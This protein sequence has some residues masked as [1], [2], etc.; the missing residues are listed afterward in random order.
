MAGP[1]IATKLHVPKPRRELVGRPRLR[2]LLPKEGG[3][4]LTLISAPAGFGKTTLLAEWLADASDGGAAVAW[5]SIDPADN[6]PAAFW[7]E[8]VAALQAAAAGRGTAFPAMPGAAQPDRSF[9]AI[10]VNEIAA[11]P[12]PVDLVLDDFHLIDHAEILDGLAF[13]IDHLPQHMRMVISTRADPALPLARLRARGELAEIRAAD[14][15]FTPSETAAYLNEV[16]GLGLTSGDTGTLE[17]RTEGWIAALQLAVLSLKGRDDV[18]GFIAEFAGSGRYIVDYLVEEVLQRQPEEVRRFLLQ[19]CILGRMSGSLC[20]A[21]TGR[22]GT[23]RPMLELLDRQNLFVV[24]L[25]DRRQWY[26]YHHLFADVLLSHMGEEERRE[27]PVLHRRASDWFELNGQPPEAIRHALAAEDFEWAA[28]LVE[29]AIPDMRRN[30]HEAIFRGWARLIPDHLIRSRP[31]LGAGYAGV[32]V[33]LGEFDGIEERLANVERELPGLAEPGGIPASI[34]LYRA[35]LAQVRGDIAAAARHAEL[36]LELAPADDHLVRAGAAGFLGIVHWTEG[37]LE[38]AGRSWT[39]CANGLRRA[40]HIADIFGATIAL[41]DIRTTEGRLTE[42]MRACESALDLATAGGR[43]TLRG[44]ADAHASLSLLHLERNEFAAARLQLGRSLGLGELFGLPQHPYRSLVARAR[45]EA[46]EGNLAAAL[47]HLGEAERRYVSD[48]FPNLRPIPAMKARLHIRLGRLDEAMRWQ[49]EAGVTADD[50][51]AFAREFEHLTL[52]RLLLA[53]AADDRALAGQALGLLDRLEPAALA[54]GRGG[55]VVE[56][57]VLRALA[58]RSHGDVSAALGA[59]R[60]ALER[61]EPE[62]HVRT[63]IDEG[64]PIT[65][66]LKLAARRDIVPA[67]ARRL[68]AAAGSEAASAPAHHPDLIEALS[69]REAELLR[70]LR[71]D[72]S[73]PDMARELGVSLNTVRTHT[74]NIYEKL[75][76]NSRRAAVRRAEELKLLTRGDGR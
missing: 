6:E 69:E 11:L 39:E 5:L 63:F 47:D 28:E 67:Y 1:L 54:G 61:G 33:S 44:T 20:D 68:L 21:V 72:L 45:L 26:R 66:L 4:R 14:L 65:A 18:S 70:L 64:E 25:D 2:A 62:G 27:L 17:E 71:S 10:L 73:G 8:V 46:A 40:G 12:A 50:A 36:V 60:R 31:A 7:P 35:A 57:A 43:P 29:R 49:R 13:L 23:G 75:G 52:A 53:R 19:T 42:A 24:A 32:L 30:R 55:S 76:V 74:R 51:P 9:L 22:G 15:R 37:N 59:V 41:A 48:F 58:H 56:I 38:A 3:A 16:M 34:E